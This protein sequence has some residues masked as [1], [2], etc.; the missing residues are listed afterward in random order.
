MIEK[1]VQAVNLPRGTETLKRLAVV[2]HYLQDSSR[3]TCVCYQKLLITV[4]I[5]EGWIKKTKRNSNP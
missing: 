5:L 2:P 1:L 4:V 3:E